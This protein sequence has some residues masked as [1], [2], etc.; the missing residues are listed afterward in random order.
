MAVN[1]KPLTNHKALTLV[2]V[3]IAVGIIAI[4]FVC[5]ILVFVQTAEI[6]K[7]ISLRYTAANIA[8]NRLEKALNLAQTKG[9][10]V[11][12]SFEETDIEVDLDGNT[13]GGSLDFKRTTTVTPNY[14]TPANARLTEVVVS[15]L[16][17]YKGSWAPAASAVTVSTLIA[18]M[19]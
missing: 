19:E 7:R 10:D 1:Y 11:L 5:V 16:Y 8:K 17:R 3:L 13:S 12:E 15:V 2:E 4:V 18:N 9:Y 14:G 6:S